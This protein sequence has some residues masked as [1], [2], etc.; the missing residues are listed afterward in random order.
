MEEGR[1]DRK[2]AGRLEWA[3]S[4]ENCGESG[5][6]DNGSGSARKKF[7]RLLRLFFS[8]MVSGGIQY[9]WALQLSLL[10]PY[11]QVAASSFFSPLL[12]LL[13]VSMPCSCCIFL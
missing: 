9:G 8:C 6:G 13:Y 7:M 12:E 4:L 3:L 10:S 5:G 2:E 1:S 11:S